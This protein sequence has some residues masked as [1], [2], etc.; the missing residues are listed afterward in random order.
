MKKQG[1]G[2]RFAERV[3]LVEKVSAAHFFREAA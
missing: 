1:S 2:K 3:A